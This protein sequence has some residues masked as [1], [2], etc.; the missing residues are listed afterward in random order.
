MNWTL[1][2]TWG[3]PRS[4]QTQIGFGFSHRCMTLYL[5][6]FGP[7]MMGRSHELNLSWKRPFVSVDVWS[8][9]DAK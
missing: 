4:L 8:P 9:Y 7:E 1:D 6:W 3:S 5:A 2:L